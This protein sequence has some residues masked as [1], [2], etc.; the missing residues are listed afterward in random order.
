ME[1][2]MRVKQDN[3]GEAENARGKNGLQQPINSQVGHIPIEEYGPYSYIVIM[4]SSLLDFKQ[5]FEELKSLLNRAGIHI[6]DL[7]GNDFEKSLL[8]D[9]NIRV[10][11]K[12]MQLV[13]DAVLLSTVN[14]SS[15]HRKVT[16]LA[17]PRLSLRTFSRCV[18]LNIFVLDASANGIIRL[19]Q[20][21]YERFV[22]LRKR[23]RPPVSGTP[24]SSKASRIVRAFLS[25]P[26]RDWSQ[27][28]L[29]KSTKIT[30]GY[31][32]KCLKLLADYSYIVMTKDSLWRVNSPE[33]LLD[34]WATHYRFD[35][36][37][38]YRFAFSSSTYDDGLQKL[39]NKLYSAGIQYAY[40][41]WSGAHLRAPYAIPPKTM[42]YVKSLPDD[43]TKL[44]LY[45]V[46][47]RENVLLILP[48][49]EGVFQFTI[50]VDGLL[51]VSDAQIYLDLKRLPG[52]AGEQ[53][54]LLRKR[55]M[56]WDGKND[57]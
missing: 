55:C 43:P 13:N 54:E 21:S 35:R 28:D 38:L 9:K 29:A 44:G 46:E 5:I 36:H 39:R 45:P 33:V 41:G 12:W 49:D 57:E 4:E 30:Q 48:H 3:L 24:F 16:I 2:K 18:E 37:K 1:S 25:E 52:R 23:R 17:T 40:T 22:E 14:S 11:V 47:E 6:Q 53:A 31:A 8:L 20:F 32:S 56:Q 15:S 7:G 19:P 50:Y 42:V 34:D 10:D 51:V 26:D 27:S